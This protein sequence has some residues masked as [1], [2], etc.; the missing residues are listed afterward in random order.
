MIKQ[1]HPEGV[2]L[3]GALLAQSGHKAYYL[4]GASSDSYR[5]YLPNHNMQFE[6]MKYA[7]DNGA[8]TYD[9][10]GVSVSRH[11]IL[12]IL[13]YGS[14]RKYG[15]QKSVKKLENSTM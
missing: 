5:E 9:F 6:M 7:R 1:E 14:S 3:S 15:E 12:R 2:I 13:D 8:K 4:Y 10:G 11:R